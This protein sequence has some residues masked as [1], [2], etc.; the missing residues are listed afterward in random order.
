MTMALL[1]KSRSIAIWGSR[2][3][4]W[5]GVVGGWQTL[6][7]GGLEIGRLDV[8]GWLVGRVGGWTNLI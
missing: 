8:G 1:W 7:G 2:G 5:G 4:V 3:G 6:E